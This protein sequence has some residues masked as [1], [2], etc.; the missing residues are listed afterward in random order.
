MQPLVSAPY[1][2]AVSDDTPRDP[3]KLTVLTRLLPL[4]R[5]H[6]ARF[7][8]AVATLLGASAITLVY[9]SVG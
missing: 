7:A 6:K 5:P 8:L 4:L 9:P 2:E 3:R 1:V